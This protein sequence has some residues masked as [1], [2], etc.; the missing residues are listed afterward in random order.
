LPTGDLVPG[1]DGYQALEIGPWAKEKLSYIQSYCEIFNSGMKNKWPVRTYIDVF[2]GPGRCI[3]ED[4]GEEID[5][6]PLI[7]LQC[8]VPF[9]HYF[10]NDI[11]VDSIQ[12]LKN[13]ST[14][15]SSANIELFNSDCNDVIRQLKS[16][17]PP[18]S[19]DFCFID[20]LNWEIAF[21]SLSFLTAG[22]NMDLAI[23]FHSGNMKRVVD[24]YPDVLNDF[25]GDDEWQFECKSAMAKGQVRRGRTLLDAYE[26]RLRKLSYVVI[27]DFTLIKNTTG[28][29][30]YH[31]VFASK[32][33]RGKDFWNKISQRTSTGQR[34]MVLE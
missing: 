22:R 7:A 16:K 19:L 11:N 31:L 8:K 9:T 18:S 27:H 33:P 1:S 29:P 28:V 2:S 10:F 23:T 6:S 4:T 5:G 32:H 30:L 14:S 15:F 24:D 25:F 26:K 21:D 12:S 3:V 13:R 17:L 20:P 34:R